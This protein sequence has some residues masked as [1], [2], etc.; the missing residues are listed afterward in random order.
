MKAQDFVNEVLADVQRGS[1]ATGV[2]VS[3]IL[4]QW[5][6]ETGALRDEGPSDYFTQ[7]HNPAGI[8]PGGVV[9]AYP[10][11][12]AGTDAWIQT[13][14][15]GYYDGVRGAQGREAQCIALGESLWAGSH[16]DDGRGPGS[17]LTEII[18]ENSFW[19]YDG[20]GPAPGPGP[21]PGGTVSV[22]LS[23]LQQGAQSDEVKSVQS[24]LNGKCSQALALDG[25]FGPATDQAV[26]S[27]QAF[28]QISVDGIVGE[29]TWTVLL[30]L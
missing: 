12:Q 2:L 23:Q 10:N 4:A 25:A 24:L 9:A 28:F 14:D 15:L 29:Q 18:N 26:R 19:L 17:M 21:Q 11:L 8:S 1:A 30:V 27:L 22:Q 7:G 6:N 16:Y 13:M 3:V 20:A 5:A